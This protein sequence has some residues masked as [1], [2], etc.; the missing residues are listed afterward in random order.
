MIILLTTTKKIE[1]NYVKLD[2]KLDFGFTP[3]AL[4]TSEIYLKIEHFHLKE[5]LKRGID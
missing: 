1:I 3:Q 2:F 5:F 4:K